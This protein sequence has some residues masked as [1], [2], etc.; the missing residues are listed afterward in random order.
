MIT[1][2]NRLRAAEEFCREGKIAADVGTDHA[3]LAVALALTKSKFVYASDV[4]EGPLEAARKTVAEYGVTNVKIVMSDGLDNIP[5][6]EDVIICGMGG[7]LITD[8]IGR[9]G[10]TDKDT[11]FILQPMTKAEFLR[12]WLYE[13]GFEISEE[14]TAYDQ[15]KAYAVMLVKYTGVRREIDDAEAYTGKITDRHFLELT[16]GKLLKNA[17]G[18][19]KSESAAAEAENLR[20][21]AGLILEKAKNL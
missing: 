10:F 13:K 3:R 20:K 4:R 19:E 18:M 6:A 17:A 15:G 12:K 1:L 16:A 5:F 7:E 11:R 8:I 14:T 21:I 2:T 9:C